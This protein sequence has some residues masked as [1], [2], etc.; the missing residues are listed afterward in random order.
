MQEGTE[1]T[2]QTPDTSIDITWR[3]E[4]RFDATGVDDVTVRL[5]SD[6]VHGGTGAGFRPLELMLISLG[7]CTG[8]DVLSILRK[9]RQQVTE[10][11]VT[12][13]GTQQQAYPR[14][15]T[16]ITIQH[17]LH[18]NDLSEEAVK[19]AIELSETKYCPA[20]AMLSQAVDIT[21]S[22]EIHPAAPPD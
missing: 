20:Y 4:M 19:R 6:A 13:Q 14:V 3:E 15:Y 5:D 16:A 8:M 21:S 11:H 12:V 22:Y 7:G 9:K 1:M 17:I 10:Y 2:G 18:G